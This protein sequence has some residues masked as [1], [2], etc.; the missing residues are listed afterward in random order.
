MLSF[1]FTINNHDY[2]LHKQSTILQINRIK[3]GDLS[4]RNSFIN[5]NKNFVIKI[6]SNFTNSYV[7]VNNSDEFSIGLIAFNESIDS[8]D[9]NRNNNF[10]IFAKKV[11]TNR[12]IDYKRKNKKHN[13]TL[14]FSSFDNSEE[15]TIFEISNVED[16]YLA[17]EIEEQLKEF[18]NILSK[19]KLNLLD[20]TNNTPKHSDTRTMCINI[21]SFVS[22][23]NKLYNEF[24]KTKKLP[25]KSILEKFNIHRI[26]IHRNKKYIIAVILA[27]RSDF[28]LL[29][30]IFHN[31]KRGV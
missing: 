12:I 21:A 27:L 17:I 26:T 24:I 8:F 3:D 1:F 4:L 15:N 2:D 30:N 16:G 18:E 11:I 10:Y 19:F 14:P 5:S 25:T 13:Y 7:D 6:I 23:D 28:D 31:I 22:K 20:L 9:E 29:A